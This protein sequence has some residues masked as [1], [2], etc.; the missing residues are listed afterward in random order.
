MKQGYWVIR[1]YESGGIGEKTKFWVEGTRPTKAGRKAKTAIKKQEQ[2]EYSAVKRFA[3]EINENFAPGD[4]LVGLDYTEKALASILAA[5]E[6]A[7]DDE[8]GRNAARAAA[9]HDRNLFLRRLKRKCDKEGVELKYLGVTSDMDGDT[10]ETVRLHHHLIVPSDCAELIKDCWHS[11]TVD[12]ERLDVQDDYLP[13]AEYLLNQVRRVPNEQKY[14]S[15]R[16]LVRPVP[17]DRT[18][19]NDSELRLPKGAELLFREGYK[20]GMPQYIRYIVPEKRYAHHKKLRESRK[21]TADDLKGEF[22]HG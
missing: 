20:P 12:I 11:G 18:A 4:L 8:A 10:G 6:G 13:I 22:E 7:E 19:L 14:T 5:A 16:N 15:S 2:N 1:T 17:K 9:V 3:R 21:R